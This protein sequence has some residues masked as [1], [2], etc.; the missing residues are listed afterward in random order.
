MITIAI[1]ICYAPGCGCSDAHV[2]DCLNSLMSASYDLICSSVLVL[3]V[4]SGVVIVKFSGFG[5]PAGSGSGLN[6]PP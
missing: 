4:C 6:L 1:A 5:D 3:C 2:L